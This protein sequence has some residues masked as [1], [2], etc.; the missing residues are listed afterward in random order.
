[1][2]SAG[3]QNKGTS[4][5]KHAWSKTCKAPLNAAGGADGYFSSF[6][7]LWVSGSEDGPRRDITVWAGGIGGLTFHLADSQHPVC[8]GADQVGWLLP[9]SGFRAVPALFFVCGVMSGS[10]TAVHRDPGELGKG[11][12]L[13]M[14]VYGQLHTYA[15]IFMY[16]CVYTLPS[17]MLINQT[18][19]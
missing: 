5:T 17:K 19:Q 10:C 4:V 2:R 9:C 1:M 8:A 13:F 18:S 3:P 7:L 11:N 16:M 15:Y 12:R 6:L 14:F